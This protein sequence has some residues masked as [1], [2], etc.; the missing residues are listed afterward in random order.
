MRSR[1]LCPS[2]ALMR[3]RWEEVRRQ[4]FET[5][6]TALI[7]QSPRDGGS[8]RPSPSH[9]L[10]TPKVGRR[11][12]GWTLQE[13]LAGAGDDETAACWRAAA[14]WGWRSEQL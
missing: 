8:P 13:E 11:I 2:V 6:G 9:F 5:L 3:S 1:G 4:K 7:G 12:S 14:C 10:P